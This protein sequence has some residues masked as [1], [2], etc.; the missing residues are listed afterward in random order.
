MET[1]QIELYFISPYFSAY[2]CAL[3]ASVV[4]IFLDILFHATTQK[5]ANK[6]SPLQ[7]IQKKISNYLRASVVDF[8]LLY[9]HHITPQKTHQQKTYQQKRTGRA[10]PLRYS[11]TS[12]HSQSEMRDPLS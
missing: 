11:F 7:N 8:F 3:R 6:N 12:P 2:L 4:N 1:I 10:R 5:R 9:A